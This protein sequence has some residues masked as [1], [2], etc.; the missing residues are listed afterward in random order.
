MLTERQLGIFDGS[1][2]ARPTAAPTCLAQAFMP[3]SFDPQVCLV[4]LALNP[5]V[6]EIASFIQVKGL[7]SEVLQ[8]TGFKSWLSFGWLGGLRQ[9]ACFAYVL[10]SS[11]ARTNS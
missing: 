8:H 5:L 10:V 4:T 9:G 1:H 6:Y 2:S 11:R 3:S 7:H